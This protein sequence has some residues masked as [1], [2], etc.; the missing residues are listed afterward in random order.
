[1]STA[2]GSIG[3]TKLQLALLIGTPI[4][5]GAGFYLYNSTRTTSPDDKKT[6]LENLKGKSISID[7]KEPDSYF[8]KKKAEVETEKLT[9]LKQAVMYKDE[10]NSC[11]KNG[12][13]DE[14]IKFYE[15]AIEKCP[16]ENRVDMAIFYQNRS[17]AYEMLKRWNQVIA[18]CSKSLEYNNKYTKAYFRR[19]K[20]HEQTKDLLKCL[21]DITATCI[22]EQFQNQN[23]IM[24]ADRILKQTGTDD[25]LKGLETR[26]PIL[27]SGCFIKTYF[28]SFVMDPL[29]LS[30]RPDKSDVRGGFLKA[31]LAFS[32]GRFE[33]VIPYCTEEIETSESESEFKSEA[34]LLRATF[35]LL[36]GRFI[37]AKVDLDALISNSEFLSLILLFLFTIFCI[38]LYSM[39]F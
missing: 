27:P 13:Y 5:I 22:L 29:N 32:E 25:A 31:K 10:G 15:K 8:D 39:L 16:E 11:F 23:S 9:P 36:S 19:A 33:E 17:A 12:K 21:D 6:K 3:I 30:E 20:A 18:D 38:L 24:Y 34:L 35:Y 1:M 14:A 37:E 28:R 7:G 4:V 26:T 2:A